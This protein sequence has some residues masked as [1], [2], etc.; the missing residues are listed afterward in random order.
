LLPTFGEE[1]R[2]EILA[3]AFRATPLI[4]YFHDLQSGA[5]NL[6]Y[7]EGRKMDEADDKSQAQRLRFEARR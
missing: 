1:A 5:L 6:E 4:A 2:H 3:G 7:G